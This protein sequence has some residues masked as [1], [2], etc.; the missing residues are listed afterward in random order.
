MLFLRARDWAAR[1]AVALCALGTLS[2]CATS[3]MDLAPVRADRAWAPETAQDGEIRPAATKGAPPE[4]DRAYVLPANARAT[5]LAPPAD[6]DPSP[7]YTLAELIDIAQS[8]N[9]LTRVAWNT[10]RDAA[11]AV[12]IAWSTYLPHLT[13]AI[14]GGYNAVDSN[15]TNSLE[16][17]LRG[18]GTVNDNGS[19]HASGGGGVATL[20]L[21]WLLFD[22]GERAAQV[23]A[24]KQ[25]S[26]ATNVAFTEVHQ[27]IAYS[28]TVAF[29]KHAAA[30]ERVAMVE[31]ALANAKDVQAAAEMR[32][33]QGETTSVD[34]AQARQ[35]TA[36]AEVRFVQARGAA[37]DTYFELMAA[38]GISPTTR[39]RVADVS[40]RSMPP[41]LIDMTETT[42]RDAVSRRPDVL[43]AYARE[44]AA[45]A[46]V[47]ATKAAFL[48]KL[49]ASGNVSYSAGSLSITS[50]PG[51]G[52]E[53]PTANLTSTG[54]SGTIIGGVVIPIYDGGV[55]AA[56]H[57]RSEN[58][59]DSARA[60]L[61]HTLDQSV[62]E[63]VV[64]D[65]ALRTSL[66]ALDA[67]HEWVRAAETTFD[68]ALSSYRSGVGSVTVAT[69]T[70]SSLLDAR[71]AEA[72]GY[73]AVQIAAATLAFA[74]GRIGEAPAGP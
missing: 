73:S 63:I 55:R 58:H 10:A 41:R 7:T 60:S 48:P 12:G 21:Q 66:A 40:G 34:V 51:I 45:E 52:Q 16:T 42:I 68:A 53:N 56:L 15:N 62:R 32:L 38:M 9:P 5:E 57:E 69:L 26:V 67:D 47:D 50:I 2:A 46:S 18:V 37:Q 49:F 31:K 24:A 59:V 43:A 74:T 44:K 4:A 6:V 65:N 14:V 22:F 28:V 17:G 39:L 19:E 71:I 33:Q 3:A 30:A 29:Y 35:A 20:G 72:D 23:S 8:H 70:E 61:R 36:Q 1:A 25:F 13:A 27:Q 54:F 64:A 11:L